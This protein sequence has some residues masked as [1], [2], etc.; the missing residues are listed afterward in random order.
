MTKPALALVAI[1]LVFAAALSIAAAADLPDGNGHDL[2]PVP[3]TPF[4]ALSTQ[5][6]CWFF[7]RDSMRFTAHPDLADV[8]NVKSIDVHP[9]TG[10][11]AYIHAE[12]RQ[13]WAHALRFRHPD[14]L[15]NMPQ[16]H[17]YKARWLRT[18][19]APLASY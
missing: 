2:S 17:L 19:R 13:W 18:V 6:G 14:G 9:V 1:A 4:L 10:R 15:L 3:G 12:G 7:D 11:L 8:P 5:G 16:E